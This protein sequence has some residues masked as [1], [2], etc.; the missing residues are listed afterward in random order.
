MNFGFGIK[1]LIDIIL[2]ALLMYQCYRLVKGTGATNIFVGI[3]VFVVMWFVVTHLFHMELLGAIFDGVFN[4]GAIALIVIFQAEIRRSFARLGSS[5]SWRI[6][7]KL[8]SKMR[9]KKGTESISFPIMK[10]VLA[11][12]NLARTKTGALII[13]GRQADLSEFIDTGETI[14]AELNT[15]LIEN[16]FFKNSPLHDGA[17][18]VVDNRIVAVSAILP[19]SRNPEI[20]RHL[21][22]RH[23]AALGVSERIDAVAIIV[24][25]ETGTISVAVDGEFM[26]NITPEQLERLLAEKL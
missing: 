22:L 10:I 18:I 25:E 12:R 9:A 2:V 8:L 20:P 19:V 14:N 15:R 21:G 7:T 24:S 16:V 6:W 11:C 3:I 1:D 26:L 5:K 4:V 13:V 23:R 17:M